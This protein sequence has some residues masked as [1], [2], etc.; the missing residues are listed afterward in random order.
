M[1]KLLLLVT[2]LTPLIF[3]NAQDDK[4]PYM[5]KSLSSE[6]IKAAK[7]ETSGGS[8]YVSGVAGSEARVEV[9]IRGANSKNQYTK[10]E[11]AK[12]LEED[13]ELNVSV[14]DNKV[15]AIA[16]QKRNNMNWKNALSISFKLYIPTASNTNLATSGGSIHLDNLNGTHDFATSGGSLH[17]D[18]LSGKIKGRTSGGSISIAHSKDNIDL[19]TSGGSITA[20]DCIGTL[21]LITSGG[22]LNLKDLLGSV[23][24]RTSGGS[25]RGNDIKADL[26]AHTSGGNVDLKDVSGSLDAATSGG[27]I[28]VELTELGKFV[29]LSNSGGN[30]NLTIPGNK[31]IDLKLSGSRINTGSLKNFSGKMEEDEVDGTLNGGGIPVTVRSSSGRVT[32]SLK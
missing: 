22:S 30:I 4:E 9:Y 29:K 2:A 1:K 21:E 17:I 31:G 26:V 32:L 7:V 10:E 11:I 5:T 15:T 16:R 28:H 20:E 23:E 18:K 27:G 19:H 25:I 3:A 14:S 12:K 13:Y 24:A 6:N 8:I